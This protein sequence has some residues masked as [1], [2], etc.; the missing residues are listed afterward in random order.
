MNM[1]VLKIYLQKIKELS[2]PFYQS[3]AD[4]CRQAHQKYLEKEKI[5]IQ[6]ERESKILMKD[7]KSV[8]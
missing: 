7:R 4:K 2:A 1:N 3:M 6:T 8:V 5:R